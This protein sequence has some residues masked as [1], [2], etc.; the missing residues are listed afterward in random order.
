MA[1]G[2]FF[3]KEYGIGPDRLYSIVGNLHE[4]EGKLSNSRNAKRVIKPFVIA[5]GE[6]EET[7]RII[8]NL[9]M[10]YNRGAKFSLFGISLLASSMFILKRIIHPSYEEEDEVEQD[11]ESG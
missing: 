4:Y 11:V 3:G 6:K 5:H 10:R 1:R 7:M 2:Q 9:V 8:D